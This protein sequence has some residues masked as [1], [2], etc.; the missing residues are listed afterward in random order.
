MV[1]LHWAG[2][3]PDTEGSV[4]CVNKLSQ[5]L[6]EGPA[7]HAKDQ[8]PPRALQ[9]IGSFEEDKAWFFLLYSKKF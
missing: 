6:L 3:L 1:R 7:L 2:G 5:V 9:V 8:E 4:L